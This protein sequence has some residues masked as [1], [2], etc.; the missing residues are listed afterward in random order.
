MIDELCSKNLR[1]PFGKTFLVYRIR[2]SGIEKNKWNLQIS[3]AVRALIRQV[4]HRSYG[5]NKSKRLAAKNSAN[6]FCAKHF[7]SARRANLAARTTRP[8]LTQKYSTAKLILSNLAFRIMHKAINLI[9]LA[10]DGINIGDSVSNV[11][12]RAPCYFLLQSRSDMVM[13]TKVATVLGCTRRVN[14]ALTH[15]L[16]AIKSDDESLSSA[17]RRCYEKQSTGAARL[18][19]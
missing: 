7:Y 10:L 15:T 1:C 19:K 11:A 17:V 2:A 16:V 13:K 18:L 6:L 3:A 9:G 12:Q 8:R 5:K 14:F 4:R